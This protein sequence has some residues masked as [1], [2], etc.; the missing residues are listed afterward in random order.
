MGGFGNVAVTEQGF[1]VL[2]VTGEAVKMGG[3][4]I[5]GVDNE[6]ISPD[7]RTKDFTAEGLEELEGCI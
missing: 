7:I 3:V 6:F 5:K 2:M 4:D 1:K